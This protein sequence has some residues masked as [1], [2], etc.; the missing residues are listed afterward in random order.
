MSSKRTLDTKVPGESNKP[1]VDDTA[2]PG[3]D[4]V[5]QEQEE[6]TEEQQQAIDT[7]ARIQAEVERRLAAR[8]PFVAPTSNSNLPDA[9]DIDATKITRAVQTK[10]GWLCPDESGKKPLR[11]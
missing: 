1:E 4:D 2:L 10:Q 11:A 5:E 9:K 7:E 6:L 8:K 3:A